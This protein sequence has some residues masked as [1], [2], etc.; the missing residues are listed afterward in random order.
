MI[1]HLAHDLALLLAAAAGLFII[2]FSDCW[3]TSMV[4]WPSQRTEGQGGHSQ[5]LLTTRVTLVDKAWVEQFQTNTTTNLSLSLS[6]SW[7]TPCLLPFTLYSHSSELLSLF[8][9][10]WPGESH[11]DYRECWH[12][13]GADEKQLAC[14]AKQLGLTDCTADQTL[15]SYR[16]SKAS[17]VW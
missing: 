11:G 2:A 12:L 14:F 4:N 17:N 10:S 16:V 7:P 3:Q 6:F 8:G 13:K 1:G 9:F 5:G 15:T